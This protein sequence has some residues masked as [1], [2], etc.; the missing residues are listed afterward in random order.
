MWHAE[1][2]EEMK[3]YNDAP[4]RKR[5]GRHG[6]LE[7]KIT[8]LQLTEG[9]YIASVGAMAC[10]PTTQEFFEHRMYYYPFTVLRNGHPLTN[11]I[12]YPVVTW[13]HQH[14]PVD[15]SATYLHPLG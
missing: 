4:F 11:L 1:T 13:D 12:F 15:K 14:D 6:W 5:A 9:D 2:D 10:N 7:A 3:N 8:P